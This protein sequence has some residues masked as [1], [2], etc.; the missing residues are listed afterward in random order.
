MKQPVRL[1]RIAIAIL[2]TIIILSC[3]A[4]LTL[5]APTADPGIQQTQISM[6]I[7]QT[8]IVMRETELAAPTAIVAAAIA[9]PTKEPVVQVVTATPES[10]TQTPLLLEPTWT[11]IPLDTATPEPSATVHSVEDRIRT[12]NILVFE[13]IRGYYDLTTWVHSAISGMDFEG[14]KILEVGDAVGDFMKA[15]NSP[16]KWDL[17]IVAAEARSAV[18][19]EFWD[20]IQEQVND[21][22]ALIAEVW[23][24]DEIANGRITPL[25]G[26]CGVSFQKDFW[27]DPDSYNVLNYS[28]YWLDPHHELFSNPNV[29]D[30]LYTPNIYWTR[31]VGDLLML[32]PGGDA[33]LL[34]GL[35]PNE[36]S[37]YGVI[38]SCLDGRVIFQT[39]S[40]HDYRQSQV[41]P[42]WQNYITYTLGNHFK[43]V[44]GE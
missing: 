23:Y 14:G 13:D 17:I 27:R 22:V 9:S 28:L 32:N 35:Y 19:G 10:P 21:D 16:V 1:E 30:P 43:A 33:R 36:K 34:S 44:E 2:S 26:K 4:P 25:M 6:G 20:V 5:S 31:D 12:A 38:A 29:V 15:L 39:F 24:L 3:S 7:Q 37:R 40:T 11:A 18:R 41:I 8:M 42:L